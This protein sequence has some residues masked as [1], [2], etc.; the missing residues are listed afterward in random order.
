MRHPVRMYKNLSDYKIL[1]KYLVTYL[2]I[3]TTYI[4]GLT[5]SVD[6]MRIAQI[7]EIVALI[8]QDCFIM[9]QIH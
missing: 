1:I 9:R 4:L 7:L 6:V 2:Y 5:K 3:F 8:G